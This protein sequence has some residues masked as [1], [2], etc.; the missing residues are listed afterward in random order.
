MV[1]FAMYGW[2]SVDML[3]WCAAFERTVTRPSMYVLFCFLGGGGGVVNFEPSYHS[4]G[5]PWTE[6]VVSSGNLSGVNS[7]FSDCGC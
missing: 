6:V 1:S 7:S 5:G 2:A 4:F 3:N